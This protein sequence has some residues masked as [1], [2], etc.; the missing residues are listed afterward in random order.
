M[1]R[2]RPAAE[3]SGDEPAEEQQ[4]AWEPSITMSREEIEEYRAKLRA[5]YHEP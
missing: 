5:Q 1:P 2:S 3:E 4:T